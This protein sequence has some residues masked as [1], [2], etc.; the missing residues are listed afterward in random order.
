MKMKTKILAV[1]AVVILAPMGLVTATGAIEP[2]EA[3]DQRG[4][5]VEVGELLEGRMNAEELV[6]FFE[7]SCDNTYTEEQDV[8]TRYLVF[9]NSKINRM[10]IYCITKEGSTNSVVWRFRINTLTNEL[11]FPR[12]Y[13]SAPATFFGTHKGLV[14]ISDLRWSSPLLC[15]F[16]DDCPAELDGDGTVGF[17]DLL[18]VL[19]NWG[20]CPETPTFMRGPI[21]CVGD[22]NGD[23]VVGSDDLQ[24]VLWSWGL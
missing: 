11:T 21:E 20:D 1:M 22:V 24:E 10:S 15:H 19:A 5:L 23:G 16:T 8:D 6:D 12:N 3:M 9:E 14:M 7:Y 18:L 4:E 2:P 13:H 17:Q